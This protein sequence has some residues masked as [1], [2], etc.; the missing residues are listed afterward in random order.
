MRLDAYYY[1]RVMPT[2]NALRETGKSREYVI[3]EIT[4]S[5]MRED[6]TWGGY[7]FT[8]VEEET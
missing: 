8:L 1:G 2:D 6:Y 4:K 7:R 5:I 3:G